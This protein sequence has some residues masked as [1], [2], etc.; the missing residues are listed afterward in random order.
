MKIA[1]LHY[2]VPP[3]VGG[4]EAVIQAHTGLLLK[5][6]FQVRLIAG[7]GA[8]QALPAGAE[9]IKIPEM[10]SRHP[11]VVELSQELE[12][13]VVPA[14]F[15]C[16]SIKLENSIRPSL[17]SVDTV[18]VHNIFTKHFNLPLTATLVH[19][20]EMGKIRQWIAWCHDF[21]WTSP[22]SRSAVHPGYPWDLLR[23]YQ[24][25]MTYVT[26]SQARQQ[27][28]VGL[29]GCRPETIRVIYNGVDPVDI[30]SLS[31]EGNELIERLDLVDEDLFLLMPVRITQAK[32]I[33]FALKI[34]ASL[35]SSGIRVKLIVTGPPDP[36]DPSDMD[37]YRSLLELRKDLHLEK[38]ARF[39]YE[40][41]S[42]PDE[43]YVI[44]LPIVRELYRVCDVL[45]M[46]SHREGFGMPILEAGMMGMPIFTVAVPAAKEIGFDEV[47]RFSPDDPIDEV[48]GRMIH[49]ARSN[50]T[51]ILRQRVRQRFTWNAI[52]QHDIRTLLTGKGGA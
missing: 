49:W 38:E 16:F 24:N 33:E 32:N 23:T 15:D 43:G 50:P 27:E 34:V 37:Y 17:E 4:V 48:A 30:Y 14:D 9:F 52:F 47:M 29:F 3:V 5:S 35:K 18:I 20:L 25:V 41:G 19:L 7:A 46:P 10:D 40:S 1:I 28:L 11:K 36:H 8:Q 45:L 12:K 31:T 13:G 42:K 44:G 39:V 51:Q 26:I 2:S 21:T 6:G 22:H